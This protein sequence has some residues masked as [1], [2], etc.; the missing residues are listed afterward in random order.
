MAVLKLQAAW[1]W[2]GGQGRE[3]GRGAERE[4]RENWKENERKGEGEEKR[5][6][7]NKKKQ[8]F[9]S[10]TFPEQ[11]T[12]CLAKF[13]GG[14]RPSLRPLA[15]ADPIFLDRQLPEPSQRA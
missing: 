7:N 15:S 5:N 10:K 6:N 3:G 12:R 4:G 1:K 14:V 8:S 13:T 11:P 2:T 9:N